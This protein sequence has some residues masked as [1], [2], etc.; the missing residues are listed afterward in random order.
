MIKRITEKYILHFDG[1]YFPV[2]F[3]G[4]FIIVL[5]AG[6]TATTTQGEESETSTVKI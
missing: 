2:Y 4:L 5:L 3:P 6:E 1:V